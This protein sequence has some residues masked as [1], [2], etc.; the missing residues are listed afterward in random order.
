MNAVRKSILLK[1]VPAV[2]LILFFLLGNTRAAQVTLI[3][4]EA[5]NPEG[6]GSSSNDQAIVLTFGEDRL[7]IHDRPLSISGS[8]L[9]AGDVARSELFL[10]R[11][12]RP[13]AERTGYTTVYSHSGFQVA[14]VPQ[15]ERLF[16]AK[17]V[18]L[19]PI[20]ASRLVTERPPLSSVKSDPKVTAVLNLL[21]RQHYEEYL[22]RLAEDLPTRY[23]C[24]NG[25][26]LARDLIRDHF[27]NLGL[28][29]TVMSFSNACG[30][31]C[32]E[33]RTGFN[34]IGVKKGTVRPQEYY[35][36]GAHY[37]SISGKPCQLAPGANDN[38]S[39]MAGVMELA[40]VFASLRT[41]ASLIFAAFSGE[42]INLGGSKKYVQSAVTSGI[43]GKIKGFVILDMISFTRNNYGVLIEG[44]N[45]KSQQRAMLKKL[46]E[47]GQTYTDLGIE[48]TTDYG[49]SDHEPFLNKGMPGALLIE[50]DWS[51]YKYYHT[52]NDLT[53]YQNT[54]YALEIVKLGAALLA[55][56]GIVSFIGP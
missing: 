22:V 10:V 5:L 53:A 36:V 40:R 6:L 44:S 47:L 16:G 17:H 20:N 42:E 55:Q 34:V 1:A 37:D 56:G 49:D 27:R 45:T 18:A 38:A 14:V 9:I 26:L 41:E 29:T 2:F 3:N 8:R 25:Q 31:K 54:P 52:A 46:A 35:L 24:S 4:Q 12:R 21:D 30:A 11:D 19:Q 43:A 13:V 51:N 48:T 33:Q 15:P 50:T 39:G 23:A 7:V 32:K 28:T